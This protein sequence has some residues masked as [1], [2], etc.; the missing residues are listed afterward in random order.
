MRKLDHGISQFVHVNPVLHVLPPVM[1]LRFTSDFVTKIMMQINLYVLK[2]PL[3]VACW[4]YFY[5]LKWI[6]GCLVSSVSCHVINKQKN[7]MQHWNFTFES[8]LFLCPPPQFT[9]NSF[10][11]EAPGELSFVPYNKFDARCNILILCNYSHLIIL[12]Q[13]GL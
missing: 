10:Q 7:L 8:Y 11:V 5:I 4:L 2:L 6:C 9:W 3:C 13:C 12:F 1:I